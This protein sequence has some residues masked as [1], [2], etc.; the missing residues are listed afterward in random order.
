ML[1]TA[2]GSSRQLG[3]LCVSAHVIITDISP[4]RNGWGVPGRGEM[5][6]RME[7]GGAKPLSNPLWVWLLPRVSDW[8]QRLVEDRQCWHHPRPGL[9]DSSSF[10]GPL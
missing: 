3:T 10:L 5:G 9:R 1:W 7:E 8:S 4:P 6:Q 2:A